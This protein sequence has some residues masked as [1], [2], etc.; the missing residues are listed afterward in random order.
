MNLTFELFNGLINR[1]I[2]EFDIRVIQCPSVVGVTIRAHIRV[3]IY[4]KEKTRPLIVVLDD[5]S[6]RK[7]LLCK[8]TL[9]KE[10]APL[11]LRNVILSKDRTKSERR[12]SKSTS[13]VSEFMIDIIC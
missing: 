6:V 3:G 13:D 11:H 5:K 8:A 4:S 2:D 1:Q 7:Q 9:I 12:G 10:T